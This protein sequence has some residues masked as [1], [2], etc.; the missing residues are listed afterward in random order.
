MPL[1]LRPTDDGRSMVLTDAA[2]RTLGLQTMVSWH[3]GGPDEYG[4][5][6]IQFIIDGKT[7]VVMADRVETGDETLP[8]ALEAFGRLSPAN[9]RR[10]VEAAAPRPQDPAMAELN[11]SFAALRATFRS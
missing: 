3:Q 5:A 8:E 1:Q 11:A 4:S 9:K 2:G 10:F 6:T 7:L